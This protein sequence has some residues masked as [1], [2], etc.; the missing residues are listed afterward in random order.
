MAVRVLTEKDIDFIKSVTT[1]IEKP[2]I[3][4]PTDGETNFWGE[5]QSSPFKCSDRFEGQ[6]DAT[7]WQIAIDKDFTNIVEQSL[8]DKVNKTSYTPTKL[9]PDTTYYVRVRYISDYHCSEWSDPVK[10]TTINAFIKTPII[11]V[12]NPGSCYPIFKLSKFEAVGLDDN[13]KSTDWQIAT[14]SGFTNII[15]QTTVTDPNKKDTLQI[16]TDI[17]QPNTTYYVRARYNGDKGHSSD[18]GVLEYTTG[19]YKLEYSVPTSVY[20]TTDINIHV[21]HDNGREFDTSKYVLKGNVSLGTLSI[22][23]MDAIWSLPDVE[24]DTPASITLWVE[25]LSGNQVTEKVTKNTTV[26]NLALAEDVDSQVD[27]TDFSSTAETNDGWD[28]SA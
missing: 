6:H 21:T 2:S 14:D 12:E 5:I 9:T 24:S 15:Y 27:V 17:L 11:T 19:Y 4:K 7:D 20:E 8:N 3:I 23:G 13:W 1:L 25:D 16:D 10:F 18:W 28:L 26:K 22:S